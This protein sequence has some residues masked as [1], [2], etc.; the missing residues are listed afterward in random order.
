MMKRIKLVVIIMLASI[1]TAFAQN[2]N[3]FVG[4]S[5]I[6]DANKSGNT[7]TTFFQISP[8]WGYIIN[9][10]IKVGAGLGLIYE[11]TRY[12]DNSSV[13]NNSFFIRF[14]GRYTIADVKKFNFFGQADVPLT[15][16][17]G[18]DVIGVELNLRPGIS[19]A[20]NETWGITL[21]MPRIMAFNVSSN[22]QMG[23]YFGLNDAYS[24]QRYILSSSFG[25][26]YK[27]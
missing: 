8:D 17:N 14:F 24:I 21:V 15:F 7:R 19:Y 20:I 6:L 9:P 1:A 23:F 22:E 4:G 13:K 11:S 27:F 12:A 3:M 26:I 18:S 25:V 16:Y 5:L 10:T 2:N